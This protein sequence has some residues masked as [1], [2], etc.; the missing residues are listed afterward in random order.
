MLY[1]ALKEINSPE[2]ELAA[3]KAAVL[4]SIGKLICRDTTKWGK[5]YVPMPSTFINGAD[6]EFIPG[7]EELCLEECN[8]IV[9]SQLDDGS[10]PITWQWCNDYKEVILADNFWKAVIAMNNMRF[11]RGMKRL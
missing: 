8:L 3:L 10:Y 4:D 1:N 9:N 5:E 2:N 11:L 6:S 7:Y